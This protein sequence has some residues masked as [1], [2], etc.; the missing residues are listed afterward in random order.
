MPFPCAVKCHNAP[1]FPESGD[2]PP[3]NSHYRMRT[4][5]I[6]YVLTGSPS[7][8][9]ISFAVLGQ[10]E[11]S[12]SIHSSTTTISQFDIGSDGEKHDYVLL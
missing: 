5:A 11:R 6:L 8:R 3:S 10:S 2:V 12:D 1:R 7:D 9:K 4:D